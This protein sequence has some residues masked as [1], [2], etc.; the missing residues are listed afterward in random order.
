MPIRKYLKHLQNVPFKIE[1]SSSTMGEADHLDDQ[2]GTNPRGTEPGE[3]TVHWP[4]CAVAHRILIRNKQSSNIENVCG[5]ESSI[6]TINGVGWI[7]LFKLLAQF[8]SPLRKPD[9]R[10]AVLKTI[11]HNSTW[12]QSQDIKPE[13]SIPTQPFKLKVLVNRL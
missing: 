2:L 12:S 6:R 3:M 9:L 11:I 10:R 4:V 1:N 13:I 7:E 5:N 8:D